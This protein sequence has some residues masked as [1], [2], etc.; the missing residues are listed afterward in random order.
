[1][2]PTTVSCLCLLYG[3]HHALLPTS[4]HFD[5]TSWTSIP[6]RI[7][8]VATLA[9]PQGQ[10]AMIAK[11]AKEFKR[12]H[13]STLL[14]MESRI[15]S[16]RSSP[17]L[18]SVTGCSRSNTSSYGGWQ[19][20]RARARQTILLEPCGS[21]DSVPII[22]TMWAVDVGDTISFQVLC[23]SVHDGRL[24]PSRPHS[25]GAGVAQDNFLTTSSCSGGNYYDYA[26]GS[27]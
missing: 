12:T 26:V 24:W 11:V 18:L 19:T 5:R 2:L 22:E 1:V 21:P 14:A 16:D 6:Q 4:H 9:C 25:C 3:G 23:S 27:F 10:D 13:L 8:S 17:G 20:R 15:G 7:W